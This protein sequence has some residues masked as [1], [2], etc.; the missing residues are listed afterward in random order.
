MCFQFLIEDILDS[1]VELEAQARLTFL[2]VPTSK[3]TF[4]PSN[5]KDNHTLNL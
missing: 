3:S 1:D 5:H 2:M 4:K